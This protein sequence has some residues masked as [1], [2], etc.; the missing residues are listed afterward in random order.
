MGNQESGAGEEGWE[1][2]FGPKKVELG[3]RGR[4]VL[5]KVG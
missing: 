5:R 2:R 3:W 1:G 4:R